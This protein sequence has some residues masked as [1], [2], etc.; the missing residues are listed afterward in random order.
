D[1]RADFGVPSPGRVVAAGEE[2]HMSRNEG[3]SRVGR[4]SRWLGAA[5]LAVA[6]IAVPTAAAAD[7]ESGDEVTIGDGWVGYGGTRL[8]P[9][10]LGEPGVGEPDFWA[11]CIEHEVEARTGI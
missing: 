2:E 8:F 6:A 3:T 10:W 1:M 4:L 7:V 9:I 11:Y 5:L